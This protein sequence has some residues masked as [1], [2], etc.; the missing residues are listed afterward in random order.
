MQGKS[1]QAQRSNLIT[2]VHQID[3][4][5][6]AIYAQDPA[7]TRRAKEI[8][9]RDPAMINFLNGVDGIK[10]TVRDEAE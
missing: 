6:R 5:M 2:V 9:R 7:H 1:N 4:T 3:G 8:L 10:I